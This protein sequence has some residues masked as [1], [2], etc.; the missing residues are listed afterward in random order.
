MTTT[1]YQSPGVYSTERDLSQRMAAVST[2]TGAIVLA[3]RRGPLG[4]NYTTSGNKYL[5]TYGF[6]DPSISPA[7][8]CILPFLD[9]APAY[10]NRVVNGATYAG[11]TVL[12]NK[13]YNQNPDDTQIAAFP[14]GGATKSY[15]D[16]AGSRNYYTLS[17]STGIVTGNVFSVNISDG[18][19]TLE[20]KNDFSG[21]F[22]SSDAAMVS[23][24]LNLTN[25][26]NSFFGT[27]GWLAQAVYDL[28]TTSNYRF[29]RISAPEGGEVMFSNARVTGGTAQAS[30]TVSDSGKLFDVYASSPGEYASS[31]ESDGIGFKI[32]DVDVGTAQQQ[33][34]TI[35]SQLQTGNTFSATVNDS[36]V[37]RY[38]RTI[39][40]ANEFVT[41]N[42]ITITINGVTTDPIV[43]TSSNSYTYA[44]LQKALE[45]VLTT[46]DSIGYDATSRT[47]TVT[48][49]GQTDITNV[50]VTGGSSQTTS[51]VSASTVVENVPFCQS[52][53]K[54]L[55]AMGM[56]I[57]Q[58]LVGTPADA[59]VDNNYIKITQLT[60]GFFPIN[61]G[62]ITI[63]GGTSQAQVNVFKSGLEFSQDLVV[64]NI[65]N[66]T[67]NGNAIDPVH[68]N[69]NSDRTLECI[70]NNINKALAAQLV[71][72]PDAIAGNQNLARTVT[73]ASPFST[74][75]YVIA[76]A[77]LVG[78]SSRPNLTVKETLTRVAPTMQFTFEVYTR[79]NT[80]TPQERFRV[81]LNEQQDG[82][83]NQLNISEVINKLNTSDYVRV[84]QPSTSSLNSIYPHLN[85]ENRWVVTDSIIWLANGDNGSAVTAANVIQG[86]GAFSNS[87][88][89]GIRI[90]INGGYSTPPVQQA[91]EALC[92]ARRD[93]FAVLDMPP[94]YQKT[95]TTC[96]NY[97]KYN[98]NINS[99]YAAIYSPDLKI[100]DEYSGNQ[101]FVPPSGHVAA[102][103]A[104]TDNNYATWFSPGGLERGKI[105]NIQGL[106]YEYDQ[107][108]RD[109]MSPNQVNAIIYKRERYTVWDDQ[110]LQSMKSA[111]S[112]IHVRRLLILVETSITNGFDYKV[113][114]PNDAFLRFQLTQIVEGILK[115]I[116]TGR[117]LYQYLIVCDEN[118][119][120]NDDTAAGQ[121]NM[122]IYL[123]PTIQARAIKL[124][125]NIV[126][127]G[128]NFTEVLASANQ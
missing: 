47:I 56:A 95:S 11:L 51:T 106:R 2:S 39:T 78:G 89:Y 22:T 62:N 102:T 57:A 114:D 21:G 27:D 5:S 93:C 111:L 64:G 34:L 124:Q 98:L 42:S 41:S 117:G 67:V 49:F 75:N 26:L 113:F 53:D 76:N 96:V 14:T 31:T 79:E 92:R 16:G 30:I 23:I 100:Y 105:S 80:S 71:T 58:Q 72:V 3:A 90:L 48:S 110:T 116:K 82:F 38:T 52:N 101:R 85:D 127:T 119:N 68:Y 35:D 87:E 121:L 73:V 107:G 123:D 103:F 74:S 128:A 12:N 54:T 24:A 28:G 29:I 125:S 44:L 104:F 109:L 18:V 33:S 43:Y 37:V 61:I 60:N 1:F 112:N 6:P 4:P 81:S 70:A 86:W 94:A 20:V 99:S 65:F 77:S 50:S 36:S 13:D 19:N 108:D 69:Q 66:C 15:E 88:K 9:E 122:D 46:T 97:R 17:F 32:V 91:M 120:S 10:V 118:N 45:E 8:D 25:N 84:Y 63:T 115:P 126:K 83:G 40:F 7:H 59:D 55:L